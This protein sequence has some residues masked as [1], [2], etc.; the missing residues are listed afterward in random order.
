MVT[1]NFFR[2]E[3]YNSHHI[4]QN[5][6]ISYPKE[7][8]VRTLRDFFKDDNYYRYVPD[9]WGFPERV[10]VTGLNIDAGIPNDSST[11]RL[12]IG[13]AFSTDVSFYPAIIVRFTGSKYTP[14]SFNRERSNVQWD[15]YAVELDGY[16]VKHFRYPKYFLFAGSWSGTIQIDIMSRGQRARDE[17]TELVGM[18]FSDIAHDSLIKSGIAVMNVSTSNISQDTDRNDL[19]HKASINLEIRSEWRRQIPV[20][21]IVEVI[22]FAIEIGRTDDPNYPISPNMT[23]YT[24]NSVITSFI[25]AVYP[26]DP[27]NIQFNFN[28]GL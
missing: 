19:I 28:S 26:Y 13:E 18:L 6:M 21:N 7:V 17:L 24:Q 4:V 15:Y 20:G 12:F 10:D 3:L 16:Q 25:N 8:I 11:T 2:S 23:I 9:H 14:I 27:E 22:N 5:G 1:N